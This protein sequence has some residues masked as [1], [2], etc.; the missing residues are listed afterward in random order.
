MLRFQSLGLVVI[1]IAVGVFVGVW[2]ST[3]ANGAPNTAAAHGTTRK[4]T[5]LPIHIKN[6][7]DSNCFD[8]H[9]VDDAD[10]QEGLRSE[11]ILSNMSVNGGGTL[12][13]PHGV[14]RDKA[15]ATKPAVATITLTMPEAGE[16]G[17]KQTLYLPQIPGY[18][19]V[20]VACKMTE[21]PRKEGLAP[22]P[23]PN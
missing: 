2:G 15:G 22:C 3:L 1:G 12:F 8:K 5:K 11:S 13:K 9:T 18:Q 10:D 20:I 23:A 7:A 17:R 19:Y 14:M 16:G 6:C 4:D 21:N